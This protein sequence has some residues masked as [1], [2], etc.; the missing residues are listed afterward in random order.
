MVMTT[1]VEP[2]MVTGQWAMS[3]LPVEEHVARGKAER[4]EIP[5]AAHATWEA[6]RD[7]P[8]PI[9]LL[10]EQAKTRVPELVPIRYGRMLASPFAFYRGAAYV[11]ASDLAAAPRS[12]LQ[13]QLCGDAHLSNFGV[14]AIPRAAPGLRHQR[15]RRDAPGTV[16]LGREAAGRQHGGGWA[17]QRHLEIGALRHHRGD[18]PPV[19]RGDAEL[20]EAQPPRRVVREPRRRADFRALRLAGGSQAPEGHGAEPREGSGE[21]QHAGLREAD[22]RRRRPAANHQRSSP[23]R[24]DG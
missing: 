10:E 22:P 18:G 4:A 3:H 21:G 5:R 24:P 11:M 2:R 13:V 1:G 17:R 14:F 6:R 15:F 20:R 16:G 23:D 19:P 8:D 7:R 9:A 12:G